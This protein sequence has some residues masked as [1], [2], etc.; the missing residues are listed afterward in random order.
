MIL[1]AHRVEKEVIR[2]K[3]ETYRLGKQTA[4]GYEEDRAYESASLLLTWTS[5]ECSMGAVKRRIITFRPPHG[6][7]SEASPHAE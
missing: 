3:R 6:A 4:I 5:R 7:V 1:S 2:T